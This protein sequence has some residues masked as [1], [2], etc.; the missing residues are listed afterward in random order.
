MC[1]KDILAMLV[2]TSKPN[3]IFFSFSMCVYMLLKK[4]NLSLTNVAFCTF[5]RKFGV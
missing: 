4:P 3:K 1:I 5:K 2:S